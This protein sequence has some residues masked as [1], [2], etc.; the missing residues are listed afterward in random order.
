MQT[1]IATRSTALAF[2]VYLRVVEVSPSRANRAKPNI[3]AIIRRVG[4]TLDL[5]TDADLLKAGLLVLSEAKRMP[6]QPHA[7]DLEHFKPIHG[8]GRKY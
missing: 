5:E 6:R 7:R 4:R 3:P 8:H 2:A 1:A